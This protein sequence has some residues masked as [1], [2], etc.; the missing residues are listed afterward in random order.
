MVFGLDRHTYSVGP[1]FF[2]RTPR[3]SPRHDAEPVSDRVRARDR[4]DKPGG[5]NGDHLRGA[6]LSPVP[7][8]TSE[9]HRLLFCALFIHL[10]HSIGMMPASGKKRPFDE[11]QA[12]DGRS[13]PFQPW[14]GSFLLRKAAA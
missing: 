11:G 3:R 12:A 8:L 14:P 2:L 10:Q 4:S 13:R 9:Y 1:H 6:A 5:I 7:W